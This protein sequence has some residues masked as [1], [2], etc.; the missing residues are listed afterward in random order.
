[1]YS[2]PAFTFTWKK[3]DRSDLGLPRQ[4]MCLEILMGFPS[5][6]AYFNFPWQIWHFQHGKDCNA[7]VS[8]VFIIII[9]IIRTTTHYD[10]SSSLLGGPAEEYSNV[11]FNLISNTLLRQFRHFPIK[12]LFRHSILITSLLIC[13]FKTLYPEVICMFYARCYNFCG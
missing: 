1:M 5:K 7:T 11:R 8:F 2:E 12:K 4:Q 6:M 10:C 13:H 3:I 9:F